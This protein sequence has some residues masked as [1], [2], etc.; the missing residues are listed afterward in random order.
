M[1]E[2][3]AIRRELA[4]ADHHVAVDDNTGEIYELMLWPMAP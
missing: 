2:M 1:L 4:G 3:R